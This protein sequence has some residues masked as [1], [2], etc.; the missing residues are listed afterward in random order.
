M[1]DQAKRDKQ[2]VI[3][4]VVGGDVGRLESALLRLAK[5]DA[6][7]FLYMT[8]QLKST[9]QTKQHLSIGLGVYSIGLPPFY[10]DDGVLYG[11]TYTDSDHFMTKDAHRSGAGIVHEEVCQ[12]VSKV[13]AEYDEGV[14]KKVR[15]LKANMEELDALLAGH[16]FADSKLASLAHVDLVR[17]QALLVAA[18]TASQ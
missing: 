9:E 11:A 6:S 7:G 4:A 10:F 16:S 14:L 13:R 1:T 12:I 8:G 2:A 5:S 3:D 15:E 17:G 18:L